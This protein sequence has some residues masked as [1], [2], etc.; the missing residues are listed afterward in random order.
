MEVL[1][2]S[3]RQQT[4]LKFMVTIR[5]YL[6]GMKGTRRFYIFL[7]IYIYFLFVFMCLTGDFKPVQV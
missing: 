1:K 7:Y 3:K 2:K 5:S 6:P 4:F